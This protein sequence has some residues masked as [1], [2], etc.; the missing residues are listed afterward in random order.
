MKN[1]ILIA[2][3]IIVVIAIILLALLTKNK[4]NDSSKSSSGTGSEVTYSDDYVP[5]IPEGY[6]SIDRT[7]I[8]NTTSNIVA[9]AVAYK[10]EGDTTKV[11]VY[12]QNRGT[13]PLPKDAVAQISLYTSYG[14]LYKFGGLIEDPFDLAVGGRTVISTQFIEAARG[15]ERAEIGFKLTEDVPE[16]SA[17]EP[18]AESEAQ[19]VENPEVE[20][21]APE[22]TINV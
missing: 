14:D 7:K 16:E 20:V 15:I 22:A 10:V 8:T 18:A 1:K 12:I 9:E 3:L 6:T 2:I 21:P 5:N 13:T 17:E 11:N 19:D 4:N